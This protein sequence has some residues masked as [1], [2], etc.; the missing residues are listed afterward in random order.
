MPSRILSLFAYTYPPPPP[1]R[2]ASTEVEIVDRVKRR[3]VPESYCLL[4]PFQRLHIP[5]LAPALEILE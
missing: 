5:L 4:V 2:L 1:S 3:R